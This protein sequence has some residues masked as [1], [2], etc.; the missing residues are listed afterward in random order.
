MPSA[1]R[2]TSSTATSTCICFRKSATRCSTVVKQTRRTRGCANAGACV[3]LAARFADRK[4]LLLDVLS[5]RFRR[6]AAALGVRTNPAFAG[7]YDFEDA[8][9]FAALFPRFL[10]GCPMAAW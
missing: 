7:T 4:G 8:A 5:Y 2:P 1:A 10:D 9:N 6:R 3:P